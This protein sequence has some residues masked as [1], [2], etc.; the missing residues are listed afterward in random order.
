[1]EHYPHLENGI[2]NVV[3]RVMRHLALKQTQKPQ[4][5]RGIPKACHSVS[6]SSGHNIGSSSHHDEDEGISRESTLSHYTYLNSF[7]PLNYQR[8]D[9]PTS[10]QQD[11]DLLFERET[12]MLNQTQQIHEEVRG[13]FKSFVLSPSAPNAP[14]KTPYTVA[15]SSSSIDY[16]PKSPTSSTSPSTN[17]YLNSPMSPHPR[18][19]P[20][21]P[22]Q[23]SGSKDITLTLSPITPLDVHFNTPSPSPPLF[24]HPIP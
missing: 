14:S 17:G 12:N 10:S 5:D 15:T 6:S 23:K 4:S 16:K 9:I 2:Y 24:Y 1:M 21:P 7:H 22:T 3:D 19:P 11:D 20:P 13:G 18:V 8:Y